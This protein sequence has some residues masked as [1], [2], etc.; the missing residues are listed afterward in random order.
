MSKKQREKVEDEV[1]YHKEMNSQQAQAAAAL[2]LSGSSSSAAST[3]GSGSQQQGSG[4][5]PDSSVFDHPQPSS[6]ESM[7]GGGG[8]GGG[9]SYPFCNEPYTSSG[10]TFPNLANAATLAA[11]AAAVNTASVA[12]SGV[13]GSVSTAGSCTND[14]ADYSGVDSTTNTFDSRPD[15]NL[16][17]PVSIS[18]GKPL[19]TSW[20]SQV[21]VFPLFLRN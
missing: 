6:T 11:A 12:V 1:R 20:C 15:L 4:S 13:T 3:T 10:Y 5:S 21:M 16:D 8:S 18:S 14:W 2:S 17:T 19:G 9:P 7:Y